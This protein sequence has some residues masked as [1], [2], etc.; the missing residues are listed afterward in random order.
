MKD[1]LTQKQ[2]WGSRSGI[3][4]SGADRAEREERDGRF[5]RLFVR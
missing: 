3:K 2:T 1:K 4:I 5:P